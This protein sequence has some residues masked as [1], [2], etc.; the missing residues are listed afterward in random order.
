M[1][2]CN[3]TA[4][5]DLTKALYAALTLAERAA[6]LRQFGTQLVV[7]ESRAERAASVVEQWRSQKPFG[8]ADFFERR[9]RLDGLTEEDLLTIAGLPTEVYSE[10]MPDPPDWILDLERLYWADVP[11]HSTNDGFVEWAEQGTNGLLWVAH[12]LIQEGFR[13]LREGMG[14]LPA[15]STPFELSTVERLVSENLL[16]TLKATVERTLALELNVA[17]LQGLLEGQQPEDRLRSFCG[18]LRQRDVRQSIAREYPVL[19][20]SLYAATRSW[21]EY[22]VELLTRLANDWDLIREEL[23]PG[24]DESNLISISAGAGDAHRRGKTVAILEFASGGKLV[25]KPRSQ[26]VDVHFGELL[27]WMNQA[28]FQAPFRILKVVSHHFLP[29]PT[30]RLL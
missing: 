14:R 7:S 1:E 17:R 22:S 4:T 30:G 21:A 27:E 2:H 13:L 19:L 10:L 16:R 6:C 9:L 24:L 28:G 29:W 12:P 11:E 15:G 18:R 23:V 20:R 5:A 25:Y 26:S 8:A 3:V